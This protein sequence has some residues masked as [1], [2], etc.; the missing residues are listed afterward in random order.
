MKTDSTNMKI[1][2]TAKGWFYA[3]NSALEA[4]RRRAIKPREVEI[5]HI[6]AKCIQMILVDFDFPVRAPR[7]D[8]ACTPVLD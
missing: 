8:D 1:E 5:R 4:R 2:L 3:A 6:L 7:F